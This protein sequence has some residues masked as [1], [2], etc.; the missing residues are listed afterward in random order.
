[1]QRLSSRDCDKWLSRTLTMKE[2]FSTAW[3]GEERR[4]KRAMEGKGRE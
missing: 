4:G 3:R 2:R 1:M